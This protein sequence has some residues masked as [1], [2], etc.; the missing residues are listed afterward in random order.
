MEVNQRLSYFPSRPY[1]DARSQ[2]ITADIYHECINDQASVISVSIVSVGDQVGP[3]FISGFTASFTQVGRPEILRLKPIGHAYLVYEFA[4]WL[5]PDTEQKLVVV[6]SPAFADD[7]FEDGE[8]ETLK[9][10]SWK[11]EFSECSS[12]KCY[13][14]AAVRKIPVLAHWVANYVRHHAH[15]D[16]ISFLRGARA[17]C[18]DNHEQLTTQPDMTG[19][20]HGEVEEVDANDEIQFTDLPLISPVRSVDVAMPTIT[21]ASMSPEADQGTQQAR[22]PSDDANEAPTWAGHHGPP[23]GKGPPPWAGHHRPPWGDGPPPWA[24]HSRPP[25]VKGPRPWAKPGSKPSWPGHTGHPHSGVSQQRVPSLTTDQI[26][27]IYLIG[28]LIGLL[29]ALL[30]TACFFICIKHRSRI[31]RDPRRRAEIMAVR[32]EWLN[33]RAYRKAA[34]K[35]RWRTFVKSIWRTQASEESE[36]QMVIAGQDDVVVDREINGLRAAHRFVGDLMRAEQGESTFTVSS[37]TTRPRSESLTSY[38]SGPPAYTS[39]QEGDISVIDGFTGYTPSNTDDTPESS[40]MDCSP[41]MSFETQR[42]S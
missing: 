40:V 26:S 15:E 23:W 35:H 39:G 3:K 19:F 31:F 20:G 32:E 6:E 33:R 38:S 42:T 30:P 41:R 5:R 37:S 7:M 14:R 12:I 8:M 2:E 16:T 18:F 13:F 24:G 10:A 4:D 25:W 36:K 27:R 1:D 29:I 34:C 11:S 22:P 9:L 28:A 21:S 17:K